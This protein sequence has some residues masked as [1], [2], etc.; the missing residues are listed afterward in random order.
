MLAHRIGAQH[1]LK[2]AR[3]N[4][5]LAGEK[6]FKPAITYDAAPLTFGKAAPAMAHPSTTIMTLLEE[7]ADV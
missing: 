5:T 3:T 2:L 1:D 6:V 7:A 4:T